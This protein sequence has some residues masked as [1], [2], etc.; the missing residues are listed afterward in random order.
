[1][2][3][4]SVHVNRE[5]PQPVIVQRRTSE[6]E[7]PAI[8]AN[9]LAERRRAIRVLVLMWLVASAPHGAQLLA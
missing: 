8:E 5:D 9:M 2:S 6:L 3:N 7:R 4:I 1:M